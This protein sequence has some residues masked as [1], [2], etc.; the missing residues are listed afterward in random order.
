MII[1]DVRL[2]IGNEG[3]NIGCLEILALVASKHYIIAPLPFR[4][5]PP[6]INPGTA[7]E[8][9]NNKPTTHSCESRCATLG[10]FAHKMIRKH[11]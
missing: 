11:T 3:L 5:S 9:L 4:A 2:P 8:S 10:L 1:G 7:V 6:R